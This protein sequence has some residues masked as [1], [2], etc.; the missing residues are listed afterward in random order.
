MRFSRRHGAGTRLHHFFGIQ[1]TSSRLHRSIWDRVPAS[2]LPGRI[3]HK[4]SASYLS[5]RTN[6]VPYRPV[7]RNCQPPFPPEPPVI[8]SYSIHYTKLYDG[9][10][11]DAVDFHG[12]LPGVFLKHIVDLRGGEHI[13]AGR[14]DP[15]R[16][17][18][19][20]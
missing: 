2:N 9:R 3:A 8:T 5:R 18:T 14:V 11:G 1:C 12:N 17:I 10:G 16:Y 6:P 7:G 15:D 13:P 20:A 4:Q 19:A